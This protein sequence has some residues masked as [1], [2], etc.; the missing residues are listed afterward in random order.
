MVVANVILV[1]D[2]ERLFNDLRKDL[3]KETNILR[4]PKSGGVSYSEN[5]IIMLVQ[6]VARSRVF[7]RAI[8]DNAV[9]EYF[10]GKSG[11]NSLFPFSFDVKFSD[12]EI[13]KIG[14]KCVL[15]V[16]CVSMLT[17]S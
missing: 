7:R 4:L 9:R 17:S 2:N 5:T 10:Y 6:V 14:G 1:L 8:R 11:I 3:P 13:F 12:V 15:L 16:L